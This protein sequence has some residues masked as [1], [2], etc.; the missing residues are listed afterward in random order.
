MINKKEQ[1]KVAVL[2]LCSVDDVAANTKQVLS[3]LS[4]IQES[5]DLV[6]LP[7]NSLF[8]KI[9]PQSPKVSLP[10]D[11][12][13]YNPFS[14]WAKDHSVHLLFGA[15]PTQTAKGV[16][17]STVWIKP[18]GSRELAYSKIHLFDVE[19][20]G[21]KPVRE[22]DQFVAGE[23]PS[24][25]EIDGWRLGLSICYDVRFAELYSEYAK[26][27]VDILAVPAAFLVPTGRAH[28][29]VL[30]RA[31]AIES[32]CYV[33][34]AAQAGVHLSPS[35]GESRESY[36]HSHVID[37]WGQVLVDIEEPRASVQVVTLERSTLAKVRA[38]IP[39]AGHRKL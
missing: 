2:Q 9:G 30:L 34:A 22:S 24:I 5:V 1:I 12:S 38:Q 32:Q 35:S 26:Q 7:E 4:Q 21:H 23:K 13:A 6:F 8:M 10:A 17:N 16:E 28:W 14:Q 25:I 19:V 39:M 27:E 31:R 3:L 36:G 15:N 20:E 37:P 18:D 11:D 33:V 29:S